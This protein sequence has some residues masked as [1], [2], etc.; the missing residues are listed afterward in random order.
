VQAPDAQAGQTVRCPLCQSVISLPG[1]PEEPAGY[2]VEQFRKCPGCKREW[3]IDTLVCTD[4]GY[5]FATRRKMRTTYQIAD[6]TIDVG[7]V[8]LGTFT[9]YR[10]FRSKL[11]RP[12]LNVSRSLLFLPLGN[13]IFDLSEYRAVL[14]DCHNG[15][16]ESSDVFYL[17]LEREDHRTVNIFSSSDEVKFKELIDLLAQTVRIEIKRR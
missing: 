10:V 3:S 9:R 2:S 4:C 13:T 11:G 15:D 17:A 6:R 14:T 16:E 8:W 12:C 5:N 1:E 7:L